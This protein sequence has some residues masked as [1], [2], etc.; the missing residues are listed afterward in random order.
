MDES[1]SFQYHPRIRCESWM[2]APT[3]GVLLLDGHINLMALFQSR[4]SD[5]VGRSTGHLMFDYASPSGCHER[6]SELT[7]PPDVVSTLDKNST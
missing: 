6:I 4:M 7:F 3:L 1:V 2:N 5:P